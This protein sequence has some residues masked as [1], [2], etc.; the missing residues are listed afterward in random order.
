[1]KISPSELR[2]KSRPIKG[3]IILQLGLQRQFT[4]LGPTGGEQAKAGE[5]L[6]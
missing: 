6:N 5:K 1:M 3:L 4:K 2:Q